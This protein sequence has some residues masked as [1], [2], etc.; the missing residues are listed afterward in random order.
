MNT[1]TAALPASL[2]ETVADV[3]VKSQTDTQPGARQ[4]DV[5]VAPNAAPFP[6]AAIG[7]TTQ[8][9]SGEPVNVLDG[10]D[11][12]G[13]GVFH[14]DDRCPSC[15]GMAEFDLGVLVVAEGDVCYLL[16]DEHSGIGFGPGEWRIWAQR[17]AG[18]HGEDVYAGD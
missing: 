4:G 11:L 18:L 7:N 8:A 12:V 10:H 14:A 5:Y 6:V 3:P 9:I 2:T 1:T 15:G 13:A 17:V 16:H